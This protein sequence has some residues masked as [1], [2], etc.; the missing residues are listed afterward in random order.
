MKR[1]GENSAV[2]RRVDILNRAMEKMIDTADKNR[3]KK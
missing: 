3:Q 1:N 2:I